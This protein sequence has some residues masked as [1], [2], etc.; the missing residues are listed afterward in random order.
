M[1]D[2]DPLRDLNAPPLNPLPGAVWVIVLA[3]ACVEAML[4][5]AT[6]GWIGGPQAIGWRLEAIQRFAFSGAIQD[7]MIETARAPPR[8]LV[9]YLSYP[10]VQ[11]GPM[12]ALLVVVMLAGLGK[13]VAEGLGPTRLLVA[14]LVP[15]VLAAV[16]FGL[17]LRGHDLA[18]LIGAWPM[19]FGLVGAYTWLQRDRAR[20][21]PG[22]Q[23]RAFG[24]IGVLLLARLGFGLLAETGHGWIADLA[25]FALGYA[26]MAATR[27]GSAGRLAA[28]LRQRG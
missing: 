18:W 2:D 13:A 27:P 1:S 8:H 5:A 24:L 3:I 15:P 16:V 9:R 21:D 23:R 19:V 25:A 12:P 6:A 26:L 28:R 11:A 14:A 10:F 7:W 17:I 4:W 22:Q 20:G